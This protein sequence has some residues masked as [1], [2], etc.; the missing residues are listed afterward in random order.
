MFGGLAGA[1]IGTIAYEAIGPALAPLAGTG[2]PIS[3]TWPTRLLA[4][5]LVPVGTAMAIALT[6]RP[7][8]PSP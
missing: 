8:R 2:D 7:A 1:V 4:R 5:L 6:G 3:T